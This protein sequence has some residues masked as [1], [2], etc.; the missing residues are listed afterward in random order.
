MK[1]TKKLI[2]LGLQNEEYSE[3]LCYLDLFMKKKN[4]TIDQ[5]QEKVSKWRDIC[6]MEENVETEVQWVVE[7]LQDFHLGDCTCDAC[8]CI[9]CH[10]ESLLGIDTIEGL[11]KHSARK[12]FGAF[13]GF[14]NNKTIGK[15]IASLSEKSELF[16]TSNPTLGQIKLVGT[17]IFRVGKKNVKLL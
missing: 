3:I 6:N 7:A 17:F 15:A 4:M 14:E 10:A 11:G 13:G 9:K 12:I 5:I 16:D 8:R 2:L 1:E